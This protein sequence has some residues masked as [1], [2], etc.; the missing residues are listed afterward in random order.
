MAISLW[1]TQPWGWS[2][3]F[4]SRRLQRLPAGNRVQGFTIGPLPLQ[5]HGLQHFLAGSYERVHVSSLQLYRAFSGPSANRLLDTFA[6]YLKN[7]C[8]LSEVIQKK[9]R[10]ERQNDALFDY[11]KSGKKITQGSIVYYLEQIQD[12]IPVIS[13]LKAFLLTGGDPDFWFDKEHIAMLKHITE[14]F[15]NGSVH[16]EGVTLEKF[17]EFRRIILGLSDQESVL[18]KISRNIP[19]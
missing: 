2:S 14:T 8:K 1:L 3:L 18:S 5:L 15:R 4:H 12:P 17:E 19:S 16:D 6:S 7:S 10:M 13:E 9:N 11:L